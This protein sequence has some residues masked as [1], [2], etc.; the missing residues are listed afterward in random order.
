VYAASR[1]SVSA[2]ATFERDEIK[3]R[4]EA[5]LGKLDAETHPHG[6]DRSEQDSASEAWSPDVA[7]G[8][9]AAWRRLGKLIAAARAWPLYEV[10][11]PGRRGNSASEQ[12]AIRTVDRL[13][14]IFDVGRNS[15]QQARALVERDPVGAVA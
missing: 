14:A 5:A 6:G 8:T 9:R 2:R 3:V 11:R 7:E 13:S 1:A 12:R 15:I 10:E 4:A